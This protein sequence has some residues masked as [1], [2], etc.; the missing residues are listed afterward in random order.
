[1]S[2]SEL[3]QLFAE[4]TVKLYDWILQR[5]YKFTYGETWRDP[6]IAELNAKDGKGIA[7]SLHTDRLAVDIN[8]FKD[9]KYLSETA[10]HAAFGAYWKSLHPLCRWGGDFKD[11]NHYS[12][13]YQGRE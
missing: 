1:M 11:G 3:Q 4:L 6:R 8:L 5:G 12:V 7:H 9:G 13:T 2:L 10:D